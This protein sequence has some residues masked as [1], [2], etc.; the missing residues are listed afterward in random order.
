MVVYVDNAL[1]KWTPPHM[2]HMTWRMSHMF[3][4]DVEELHGFA[5]KLGLKRSWFQ[6]PPKASWL[7]YDLSATYRLKALKLGAEP[8]E[9]RALPAKL[10]ELGLR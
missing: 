4:P 5:L 9:W 2:P 1:I 3:S 6:C 10:R 8:I 7:H